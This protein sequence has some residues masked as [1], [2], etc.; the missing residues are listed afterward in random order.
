M[1]HRPWCRGR[2]F[3]VED[4]TTSPRVVAGI[5]GDLIGINTT[6]APPGIPHTASEILLVEL[7]FQK[8]IKSLTFGTAKIPYF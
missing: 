8:A 6:S 5:A 3:V 1:N 4:A 7:P 2:F